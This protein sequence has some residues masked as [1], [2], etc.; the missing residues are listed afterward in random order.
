MTEEELERWKELERFKADEQ[1]RVEDRKDELDRNRLHYEVTNAFFRE[2]QVVVLGAVMNFA[3]IAIRSLLL[4]NG[5]ALVALLT[6]TGGV[7]SRAPAEGKQ[8]VLTLHEGLLAFGG[9]VIACLLTSFSSYIAQSA[10]AHAGTEEGRVKRL[11]LW[12][13]ATGVI[14]GFL[15]LV[16]FIYGAWSA[17][18][19]FKH[20]PEWEAAQLI[21]SA[22]AADG[23]PDGDGTVRRATALDGDTIVVGGKRLRLWG[24]DAPE[25]DDPRGPVSRAAID[26]LLRQGPVDCTIVDKAKSKRPVA[27][28]SVPGPGGPQDLGE[29]QLAAGMAFVYRTFVLGTEWG[30]RYDAAERRAIETG[31]GFWTTAEPT[32]HGEDALTLRWWLDKLTTLIVGILAV[33]AAF[34]TA[35]AIRQSAEHAT[36]ENQR[37][38]DLRLKLELFERR[39]EVYEAVLTLLARMYDEGNTKA[40]DERLKRAWRAFRDAEFLFPE[41]EADHVG[42]VVRTYTRY[43]RHQSMR[44]RQ[45]ELAERDDWTS[46]FHEMEDWLDQQFDTVQTMLIPYLDLTSAGYERRQGSAK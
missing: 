24:I 29:A 23:E 15:S 40:A 44:A 41:T 7:W 21:P 11:G 39:V 33:G 3:T 42:L 45:P 28:C 46:K 13:Q 25:M 18:A 43:K 16:A 20:V 34:L 38:N 30:A 32:P 2:Q 31:A 12:F 14:F 5:G 35:R 9:G 19:G 36:S 8:L 4:I 17:A 6:L 26:G 37:A 22:M 1:I 27:R 10:F